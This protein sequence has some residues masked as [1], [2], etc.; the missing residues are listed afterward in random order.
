MVNHAM[1]TLLRGITGWCMH[2]V[3]ASDTFILKH[4]IGMEEEGVVVGMEEL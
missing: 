2:A 1:L 3:S 4:V